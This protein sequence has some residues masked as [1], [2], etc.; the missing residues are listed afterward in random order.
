MRILLLLPP[1]LLSLIPGIGHSAVRLSPPTVVHRDAAAAQSYRQ[2]LVQVPDSNPVRDKVYAMLQDAGLQFSHQLPRIRWAMWTAALPLDRTTLAALQQALAAIDPS[3]RLQPNLRYHLSVRPSDPDY[4]L[5]WAL[6]NT[7]QD[8]PYIPDSADNEDPTIPQDNGQ[9]GMDIGIEQAWGF[10]PDAQ[11]IVVAVLDSGLAQDTPDLAGMAVAT[12]YDFCEDD[13]DP[14]DDVGHGTA[15]AGL[16]AATHDNSLG[17]AG[18][19]PGVS[20]MPLR[21]IGNRFPSEAECSGANPPATCECN[22]TS[23]AIHA[24]D[25]AID[26]GADII[27]MSFGGPDEDP[28]LRDA[29]AAAV[30]AG[31][32]LVAAA[33]NEALDLDETPSYPASFDLEGMLSVGSHTNDGHLSSFSNYGAVIH[34]AAPGSTI[35]LPNP[36]A[37]DRFSF[38]NFDDLPDSVGVI[39]LGYRLA[40]GG[41]SDFGLSANGRWGVATLITGDKV[42]VMDVDRALNGEE[43][44]SAASDGIWTSDA[45][46]VADHTQ[47]R[48][49]IFAELAGNDKILLEVSRDGSSWTTV[50]VI[51]GEFAAPIE[52]PMDEIFSTTTSQVYVRIRPEISTGSDT[53]LPGGAYISHVQLWERTDSALADLP[54]F[55]YIQGTSFAAPYVAAVAALLKAQ[56]ASLS[57]AALAARITGSAAKMSDTDGQIPANRRLDAAAALNPSPRLFI[58]GT[59]RFRSVPYFPASPKSGEPT[60]FRVAYVDPLTHPVPQ[61][62]T[63][64]LAAE[65]HN[66][67]QTVELAQVVTRSTDHYYEYAAIYTFARDASWSYDISTTLDDGLFVQGPS[68]KIKVDE[69][70]NSSFPETDTTAM[71]DAGGCSCTVVR[72]DRMY[73]CPMRSTPGLGWWVTLLLWAMSWISLRSRPNGSD[74]RA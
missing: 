9:S 14:D 5:Q 71:D 30:E 46:A 6:R 47:L 11:G 23:A 49:E 26:N 43:G 13:A 41:N 56:N 48:A 37:T 70:I 62:V 51:E 31:I 18:A 63:L 58:P 57:P 16:I 8:L 2:L 66:F 65:A 59:S 15:I 36:N 64:Q 21:F 52:V 28:A 38:D 44:Y 29:L 61:T 22:Y 74:P 19:A 10:Q 32:F 35:W 1:L 60:E 25:Y 53:G 50:V 7:G 42:A 72:A 12:G 17:I 55:S 67:S 3:A 4:R 39:D 68:G 40:M 24:L 20:I 45:I 54:A 33:G 34:L 27:N 69:G 73:P